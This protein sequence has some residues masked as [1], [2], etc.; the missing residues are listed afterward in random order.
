VEKVKKRIERKE[1]EEVKYI[2]SV[3]VLVVVGA[4]PL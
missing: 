4:V 1:K 2:S 3:V